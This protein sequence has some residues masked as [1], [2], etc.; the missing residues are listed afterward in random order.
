MLAGS[1][2]AQ[3]LLGFAANLVLVRYLSPAE[4]GTYAVT[5]AI[6]ATAFSLMTLRLTPLIIRD[7]S[8]EENPCRGR[9]YSGA[10][11]VET[12]AA[13]AIS[14]ASVIILGELD[15]LSVLL[16]LTVAGTH[17]L[18]I[19]RG[20]F[21]RRMR[22]AQSAAVEIV[23]ALVSHAAAVGMILASS[24][25]AAL[26]VRDAITLI[27]SVVGLWIVGG[28]HLPR[29]RL[30]S[31]GEWKALLSQGG[32]LWLDGI[33]EGLFQRLTIMTAAWFGGARDAGF[34]FQAQRLAA[35]PHQILFPLVTRT[36]MVWL[37]QLTDPRVRR[38]GRGRLLAFTSVPLG[39]TV[40]A[41]L[42]LSELLVPWLFGEPWRPVAPLL[43]WLSGAIMFVTLFEIARV[44]C[45]ATA[46]TVILLSGRVAQY[47]ACGIVLAP[48][49]IG[50]DGSVT[51]LAAAT[52]ACFTVAFGLILYLLRRAE[53]TQLA[54]AR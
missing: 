32:G 17:A 54:P 42:L 29:P 36:A 15:Y 49:L 30:L 37:S 11:V 46:Q 6:T 38:A 1:G 26:Y 14:F 41:V 51:V 39:A 48:W 33:L 16:I 3:A 18:S 52:S 24:G 40:L 23:T 22:L 35:V 12:V 5:L 19:V 31:L 28:L 25:A 13:T 53:R 45:L 27:V 7:P 43:M 4:F 34:F 2:L 10:M 47:A 20:F 44:F 9:M 21:E 50:R 8:L